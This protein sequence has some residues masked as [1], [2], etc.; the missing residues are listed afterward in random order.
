[1]ASVF[2]T[3]LWLFCLC[4]LTHL[5]PPKQWLH[6]PHRLSLIAPIDQR[7]HFSEDIYDADIQTVGLIS[8]IPEII[9]LV[10]RPLFA[11]LADYVRSKPDAYSTG[12]VSDRFFS[13][14][15]NYVRILFSQWPRATM[16]N[17]NKIFWENTP[18]IIPTSNLFT[19]LV[20]HNLVSI[21]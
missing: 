8:G 2:T 13:S 1:M 14:K 17:K 9:S 7:Y 18:E 5:T 15:K 6:S 11:S 19:T 3:E 12:K 20:V 4:L 21:N 16:S 10:T